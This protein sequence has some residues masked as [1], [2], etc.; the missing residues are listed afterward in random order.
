MQKATTKLGSMQMRRYLHRYKK[1]PT[2][3]PPILNLGNICV[4]DGS[5]TSTAQ[6]SGC[7]WIWVDSLRKIQRMGMR[8]LRRQEATLHTELKILPWAMESMFQRSTCQSFET[9]CKDLI[10]MINDSHASSSFT[11]ELEVI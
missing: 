11:T 2:E 3:E 6:L 5:R 4:V 9:D 1:N 8:N 10:A 7:G